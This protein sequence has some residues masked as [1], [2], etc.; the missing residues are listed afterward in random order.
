MEK[1]NRQKKEGG[2]KMDG[3][4]FVL[5]VLAV[6]LVLG[7]FLWLRHKD[8]QAKKYAEQHACEWVAVGGFDICK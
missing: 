4:D 3:A 5:L 2:R 1:K 8:E 6:L 7:G